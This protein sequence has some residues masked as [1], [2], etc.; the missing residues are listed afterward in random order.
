M[1]N[2]PSPFFSTSY[3]INTY[4]DV[5]SAGT[6]PL[7]QFEQQGWLEGYN[8]AP[9][10][11][12]KNLE[13]TIP[14]ISTGEDPVIA[15]IQSLEYTDAICTAAPNSK[16][17]V[18]LSNSTGSASANA[19]T[20]NATLAVTAD[21]GA[22][23]TIAMGSATPTTFTI[24][25]TGSWSYGYA[26]A[27]L[28]DGS[29]A[30]TVTETVVGGATSVA[31]LDFTFQA[32]PTVTA[33]STTAPG[34]M[35]LG[36]GNVA[37]VTLT[38]S[39]AVQ[40]TGQPTLTLNDGGVAHYL[41]GSG[42]EALTFTYTVVAG[43]STTALAVTAVNMPTGASVADSAGNAANF[44]GAFA[45]LP[46]PVVIETQLPG[47]GSNVTFGSGAQ[48]TATQAINN[49]TIALGGA[50][51]TS[52]PIVDATSATFGGQM[53]VS[54]TG[55]GAVGQYGSV[56]VIGSDMN[57][58]RIVTRESSAGGAATLAISISNGPITT[59]A[60]AVPGVLENVGTI[61]AG[62]GTTIDITTTAAGSLLNAGN[63]DLQR[64]DVPRNRDL[65]NG[66]NHRWQHVGNGRHT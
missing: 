21:P 5:V 14:D 27:A 55:A 35:A 12:T 6:S 62:A 53:T 58:G 57:G 41:S 34:A 23:L 49:Y 33:V 51:A 24:G 42:G 50:S 26:P 54:V 32:P 29:Y 9:D 46:G 30:V 2:D 66:P 44:A 31:T 45:P 47:T 17:T 10:I 60:A 56:A 36:A 28:A 3:Y 8:P 52:A 15:Y 13:Q 22:T 16:L 59:G 61:D 4:A 39:E 64:H 43:Q 37:T 63:L 38:F 11:N 65:G 40:V 7:T 48:V 18:S 25:S 20:D 19:L 1:G